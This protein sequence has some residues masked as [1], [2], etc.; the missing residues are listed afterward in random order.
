MLVTQTL[1]NC[2]SDE[3]LSVQE[4]LS[5]AIKCRS[6]VNC[7]RYS[8]APC[9]QTDRSPAD[10]AALTREVTGK[11]PSSLCRELS[12]GPQR[13]VVWGPPPSSA[14]CC[15]SGK[16]PGCFSRTACAF[17]EGRREPPGKGGAS[18]PLVGAFDSAWTGPGRLSF[19]V[20]DGAV[21]GGSRL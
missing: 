2:S 15:S 21:C 11:C 13:G 7:C 12:L 14:I 9:V 19:A 10:L 5:W 6:R 8:N 4:V 20:T 1:G 18:L 16:S 3:T 17:P